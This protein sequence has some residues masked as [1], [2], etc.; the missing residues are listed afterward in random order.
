MGRFLLMLPLILL[1]GW[2]AGAQSPEE[3]YTEYITPETQAIME[4]FEQM[5]IRTQEAEAKESSR[6]NLALSVSILI[7]LIPLGVLGRKIIKGK[8]WKENPSGTVRALGVG[9][10]GGAVLFALNY[11]V[12]FLK[13]RLGDAFNTGLAFL[14]VAAMV[15]VCIYGLRRK[16]DG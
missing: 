8:T 16:G 7:G 5:Q 14:L 4:R 1:T 10:L 3:M 11:G 6:K 13:M 15:A 12:F 2:W 9:L